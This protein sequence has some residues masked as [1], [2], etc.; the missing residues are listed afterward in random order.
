[1]RRLLHTFTQRGALM[2]VL[3]VAAIMLALL[4]AQGTTVLAGPWA[5][6]P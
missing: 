5:A 2:K 1:M 6:G 3:V 4:I